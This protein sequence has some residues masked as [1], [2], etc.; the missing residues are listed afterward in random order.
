M[1]D[2]NFL[3]SFEVGWLG[4]SLRGWEAVVGQKGLFLILPCIIH[5]PSTK[6]FKCCI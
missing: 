2:G 4:G 6:S 5:L 3:C 1:E